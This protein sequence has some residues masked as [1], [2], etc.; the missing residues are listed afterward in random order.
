MIAKQ[1]VKPVRVIRRDDVPHA[2]AFRK[3]STPE[4]ADF[5][6]VG[7]ILVSASVSNTSK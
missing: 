5:R 4:D 6:H 3:R 2:R 7:D 1:G